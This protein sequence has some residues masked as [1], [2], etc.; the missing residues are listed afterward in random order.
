MESSIAV[1]F[2]QRILSERTGG[3]SPKIVGLKPK[4]EICS[5]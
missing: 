5:S 1:A 3:F 4:T 2:R